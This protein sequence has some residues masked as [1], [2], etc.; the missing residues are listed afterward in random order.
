MSRLLLILVLS[1]FGYPAEAGGLLG[2]QGKPVFHGEFHN[3][4]ELQNETLSQ[5]QQTN[6]PEN[7]I[8]EMVWW[9]SVL[10]ALCNN[11][12]SLNMHL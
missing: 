12:V 2:F 7:R 9:L 6:K 5:N 4:L 1:V 10:V 8:G 11:R 3:S